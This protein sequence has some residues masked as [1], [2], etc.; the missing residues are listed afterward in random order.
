V[1][2]RIW[3]RRCCRSRV[4]LWLVALVVGI[5]VSLPL[6]HC[7]GDRGQHLRA[8]QHHQ[9]PITIAGAPAINVAAMTA[10]PHVG[11]TLHAAWCSVFDVPALSVRTDGPLRV[12]VTVGVMLGAGALGALWSG[13]ECRGSPRRR[14]C[15][16]IPRF[17]RVLL[18]DLCVIRC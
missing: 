9:A 7:I 16:G 4:R 18:T 1:A 15:P 6:A 12:L 3:G 5:T 2:V 17:G 14:R 11:S 13:R 8:P 10:H